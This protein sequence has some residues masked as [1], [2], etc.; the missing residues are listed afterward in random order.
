MAKSAMKK[1]ASI[2]PLDVANDPNQLADFFHKL[3]GK[4]FKTRKPAKNL[5][6]FDEIKMP[7]RK[8]HLVQAANEID[9]IFNIE[10][11]LAL[12]FAQGSFR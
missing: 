5:K 12:R 9:A 7:D 8:P 6:G 10:D 11:G 2:V 1:H 3:A 4:L